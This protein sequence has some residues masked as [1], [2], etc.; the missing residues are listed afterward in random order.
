MINTDPFSKLLEERCL[1]MTV[2]S[3]LSGIPQKDLVAFTKGRKVTAHL[4]GQLCSVL[5]CQPCDI[6]EFSKSETKGHWE[7]IADKAE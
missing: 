7:G 4:V 5:K 3:Q 1:T 2:V 6:L